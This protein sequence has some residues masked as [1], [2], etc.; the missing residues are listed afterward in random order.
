MKI[1]I[2]KLD[3]E[4]MLALVV[5]ALYLAIMGFILS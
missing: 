4:L 1:L 2:D 3:F 5:L